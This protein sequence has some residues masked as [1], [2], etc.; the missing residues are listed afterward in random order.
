MNPFH[1]SF[2]G[3]NHF[4]I[5]I[6]QQLDDSDILVSYNG[7]KA[8]CPEAILL[9]IIVIERFLSHTFLTRYP[10]LYINIISDE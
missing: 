5:T 4:T 3:L 10:G 9:H 7:K 8:V 2:L 1:V 6:Q